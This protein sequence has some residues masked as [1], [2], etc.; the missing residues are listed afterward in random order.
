MNDCNGQSLRETRNATSARCKKPATGFPGR[1]LKFFD[2][3]YM[4]VICPTCQIFRR[5]VR[6]GRRYHA[7]PKAGRKVYIRAK[8]RKRKIQGSVSARFLKRLGARTLMQLPGTRRKPSISRMSK[9]AVSTCF[10]CAG[11]SFELTLVHADRREQE[12]HTGSVF[13]MRRAGRRH[14][15]GNRASDRGPEESGR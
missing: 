2:A 5:R 3:K 15:S 7:A 9:M 12:A 1:G 13:S 4:Q 6:S 11:H 8:G 10:K 14:G